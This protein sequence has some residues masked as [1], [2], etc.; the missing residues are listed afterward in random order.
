MNACVQEEEVVGVLRV[1]EM[2]QENVAEVG[3]TNADIASRASRPYAFCWFDQ[4][5]GTVKLLDRRL[6]AQSLSTDSAVI[7]GDRCR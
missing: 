2:K 4:T 6:T 1:S 5:T 3:N 7:E